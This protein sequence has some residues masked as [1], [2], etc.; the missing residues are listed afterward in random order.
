MIR[1]QEL[2]LAWLCSDLVTSKSEH[3]LLDV[4]KG[5]EDHGSI[6]F[7]AKEHDEDT[8]VIVVELNNYPIGIVVDSVEE[9]VKIPD[10]SVQ[11]LPESTSTTESQE[12]ITG[13]GMLE[14]RL[15]ILLDL[16]R[17]LTDKALIH[18]DELKHTIDAIQSVEMPESAT[19]QTDDTQPP[20]LVTGEKPTT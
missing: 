7:E 17:I 11:N 15:I 12:H 20:E 4:K 9:V 13:I 5:I 2:S 10:S 1:T 6:G 19:V 18:I 8:R 16:D 3:L 14:K